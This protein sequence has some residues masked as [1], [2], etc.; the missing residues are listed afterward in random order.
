MTSI[1][2]Q[3]YSVRND[4]E[5]NPERTLR[6]IQANGFRVVE[7]APM[8][9]HCSP[10]Q[11]GLMLRAAGLGV[12]AAHLPLPIGEN[13]QQVLD[14]AVALGTNRLIWHGWPRD[15]LSE[16]LD[17]FRR[18]VDL[19]LE[20]HEFAHSQGFELGLHNHW[21]EF[22]PYPQGYPYQF[23]HEWLPAEVF[24]E[25]DVY[26]VRTAGLDPARV[27]VELGSRVKLLHMKDGPARH[28]VPMTAVGR[29]VVDFPS[30]LEAAPASAGWIVEL[31]ECASDPLEAA[32]S[33]RCYLE[34]LDWNRETTLTQSVGE[35]A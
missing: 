33:S 22:E 35:G 9:A 8:P 18:I 11:F 25:L 30:I 3:L 6:R 13:R 23:L 34:S 14:D 31:D 28:G 24:L 1:A 26:W 15:P 10:R 19:I 20:A 21:W 7:T 12:V 17:G 2:L 16:T 32:R 27:L 4:L 29:G 5:S